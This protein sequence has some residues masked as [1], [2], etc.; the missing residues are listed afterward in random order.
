MKCS[1]C[2]QEGHRANSK[3]FHPTIAEPG[4]SPPLKDKKTHRTKA[5]AGHNET[6]DITLIVDGIHNRTPRGL[7]I[8]NSYKERLGLE[9]LDARTRS[10][11]RKKHYDYEILVGPAPGVWKRVEHKGS[12]HYRPIKPDERPWDAGVQ[13]H[14]GGCEKYAIAR[15]YTKA[16]YDTQIGSG[17]LKAEWNIV[18]PIPSYEEWY[19][20]D[21]KA[22][23]KPKTAFGKEL[24][25]KVSAAGGHLRDK[26]AIVQAAF[27][28]TP[29]DMETF[30][31]ELLTIMNDV[32]SQKDYWL[33]IHGDLEGDFHCAWYPQFLIGDIEEIVMKKELDIWFDIKCSGTSFKTI[34]R[35]G[36]ALFSNFRMDAR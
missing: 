30:K 13:F 12:K 34:L 33:T 15:L 28:P 25:E 5:R 7:K 27:N 26:R 35:S 19:A 20:K 4:T 21:A 2:R 6:R 1:I 9:I 36:S 16:W 23:A 24:K 17:A 32:L 31:G 18:A 10:A 8:I 29:A 11:G 14:N 3:I 22:Q